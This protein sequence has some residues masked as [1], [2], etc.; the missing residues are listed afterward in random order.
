MEYSYIE[1]THS[2][3][4][5]I[6]LLGIISITLHLYLYKDGVEKK[7]TKLSKLQKKIFEAQRKGDIRLAGE[8][9]L[10]AEKLEKQIINE[11]G[12]Q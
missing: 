11:R 1:F 7:I 6:F 5:T 9:S 10:E 8:L 12:E 2:L 4:W 3:L